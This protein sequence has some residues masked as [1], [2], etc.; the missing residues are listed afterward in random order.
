MHYRW[1]IVFGVL[2]G[3]G[4]IFN[5][6]SPQRV[7]RVHVSTAGTFINHLLNGHVG[8]IPAYAHADFHETGN[9]PCI[10]TQRPFTLG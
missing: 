9:N 8:F 6:R 4:R 3:T 5:N 7:V 10:L 2:T 1:R